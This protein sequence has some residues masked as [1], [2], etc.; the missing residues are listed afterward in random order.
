[1]NPEELFPIE[2]VTA[3]SPRLA[4]M[5]KHGIVTYHSLP[6]DPEAHCWFAGFW[7]FSEDFPENEDEAANED[8]TGELLFLFEHGH[9]GDTRTGKGE[10]EEEALVDLCS[11]FDLKL[12]NEEAP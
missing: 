8:R 7:D 4:W 5:K 10:T 6:N 2:A 11:M 12:W 9:N 1:M 3:D